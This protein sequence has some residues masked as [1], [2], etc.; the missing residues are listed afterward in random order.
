[1]IQKGLKEPGDKL[2]LIRVLSLAEVL[3]RLE[4]KT[5]GNDE[6]VPFREGLGKLA[7]GLGLETSKLV[8]EV[9]F[10][11]S[12]EYWRLSCIEIGHT[13]LRP[14]LCRPRRACE[15]TPS[16]PPLSWG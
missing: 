2:Q 6:D 7:N 5:R 11:S 10:V 15:I 3:T 16:H 9:H 14:S 4:E 13:T 12:S 1:M 8:D